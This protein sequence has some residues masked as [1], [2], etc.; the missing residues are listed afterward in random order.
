VL[1]IVKCDGERIE[2]H[3]CGVIKRQSMLSLVISSHSLITGETVLEKGEG[4]M[5]GVR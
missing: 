5:R 1:G 4:S 2:E 3:R